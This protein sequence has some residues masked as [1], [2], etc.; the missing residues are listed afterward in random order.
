MIVRLSGHPLVQDSLSGPSGFLGSIVPPHRS[1]RDVLPPKGRNFGNTSSSPPAPL[2]VISS[3][4]FV[5]AIVVL[6]LLLAL[7]AVVVCII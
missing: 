1:N 5:Q 3:L 7:V 4:Y 6:Y 2:L